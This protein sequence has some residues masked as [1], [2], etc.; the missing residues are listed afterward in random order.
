M[1]HR[2][3][4][5]PQEEPNEPKSFGAAGK[6][7]LKPGLYVVSTPIGNARD[8]TLRALD[9]LAASDLV[10]AED[11]R[12]TAKL[13]AIHAL[14]VPLAVYNDHNAARERPRIL[15]RLRAGARVALVSDAGTPL[16][17]DPGF[18]LVRD[19][20]A[21][22]ISVEVVPGPSAAIAG[23]VLSGLPTDRFL[24]AGFLPSRTAERRRVLEELKD[25]RATL[26][27]FES[28]R[29]LGEVLA[30][31]TAVWGERDVAVMRELTKFH[32]ETQRG[33]L[34]GLSDFYAAR[35]TPKGEIT[36]AVAGAARASDDDE[37][38][39]PLLS[40]AM[41]Y[42]PLRE[43]VDLI[44]GASGKSRTKIYARAL[45]IKDDVEA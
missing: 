31:M 9:V 20:A 41:K 16:V 3:S 42:M 5:E 13:F 6:S 10:L 26:I 27:F 29:R 18:K 45:E 28:A 37:Q 38:L 32:E 21:E 36:I 15:A 14:R 30:D 12:V 17:S 35:E 7:P 11:T 1:K 34:A 22:G 39:A 23:L 8:I 19:A 25:V 4:D 24:F 33:T 2:S 44:S 43:A 40:R